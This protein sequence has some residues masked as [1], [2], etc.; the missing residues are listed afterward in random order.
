[1]GSA[2]HSALHEDSWRSAL[3]SPHPETRVY[4][5]HANMKIRVLCNSLW[6]L[7]GCILGRVEDAS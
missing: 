1:M 4:G 2:H 7:M 6:A 5:S 3:C